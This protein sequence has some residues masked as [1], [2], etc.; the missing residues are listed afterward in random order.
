M[1]SEE[2]RGLALRNNWMDALSGASSEDWSALPPELLEMIGSNLTEGAHMQNAAMVCKSWNA[3][4]ATGLTSMEVD[5]HS[6]PGMWRSKIVKL[7]SLIRHLRCVVIHVNAAITDDMLFQNIALVQQLKGVSELKLHLREGCDLPPAA[8]AAI[9]AMPHLTSLSVIGGNLKPDAAA[10]LLSSVAASS[11]C[12]VV[13]GLGLRSLTLLP[14]VPYG[15]GD[16]EMAVLSACSSLEVLEFRAYRLTSAGLATLSLGLPRLTRLA[17]TS[18]DSDSG[19]ELACL[20]RLAQLAELDLALDNAPIGA[21]SRRALCAVKPGRSLSLSFRW[22]DKAQGLLTEYGNRLANLTHLDVGACRV[23]SESLFEAVAQLTG[24]RELRMAVYSNADHCIPCHLSRLSALAALQRFQLEKRRAYFPEARRFGE[25]SIAVPVTAEGLRSLAGRWSRLRSLRLALSRKDYSPEALS[26][27]SNFTG[28]RDLGILVERY[29]GSSSTSSS[30]SSGPQQQQQEGVQEGSG[31]SFTHPAHASIASSSSGSSCNVGL[32]RLHRRTVE[33]PPVLDLA[34]L[35]PGLQSLELN[36]LLLDLDEPA[37]SLT[38]AAPSLQP[39]PL[40][41]LTNLD[42]EACV[43]RQLLLPQVARRCAASLRSLRLAGVVGL[44]DAV[45]SEC[46]TALP[47]LRSLTV[48]APGN[49]AVSQAS[50]AAL[51]ASHT[52]REVVKGIPVTDD[53]GSGSTTAA[54]AA[55]PWRR[56]PQQHHQRPLLPLLRHLTWESE[57][58]TARGPDLSTLAPLTALRHLY[59]S[60]TDKTAERALG[61]L[62]V[63][64]EALPYCHV[65]MVWTTARPGD[66]L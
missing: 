54:A 45:L 55:T 22:T 26:V 1:S 58:L 59:L 56:F 46:L 33:L 39:L 30:S 29:P 63:L 15:L 36:N 10:S 6:D 27:L 62:R 57:D 31:G 64:Q 12:D 18:L 19:Y 3:S 17:I 37:A 48:S 50:L 11:A 8:A 41:H 24:L 2:E 35:P 66:V 32:G 44:C 20:E 14:A 38:V 43:V 65:D 25:S 5:M 42:I 40:S 60:C 49:R 7:Q 13:G 61:S 4:I 9:G 34:W 16:A 21:A 53:D 51:S 23:G 47:M 52:S 28:L